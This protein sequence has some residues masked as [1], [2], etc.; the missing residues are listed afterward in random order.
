MANKMLFTGGRIITMAE[1][2]QA[3]LVENGKIQAVGT[4]EELRRQ[5]PDASVR[6]LEGKVL[7]PAFLDG[8]S[9]MTSLATTFQAVSLEKAGSLEE[10]ENL[11]C[12]AAAKQPEGE[13]LIGFGYDHNLLREG[14]H[15]DRMMLDR[16]SDRIP[17]LISHKSGHMGAANTAALRLMGVDL[18]QQDPEG[19]R[20]GRLPDGSLSGYLEETAFTNLA[21]RLPK[22]GLDK[23]LWALE[24]AQQVY[25]SNGITTVQDG[26]TSPEEW[27]LLQEFA[28]QGRLLVDLVCYPPFEQGLELVEAHPEWRTYQNHLRIGGLK[29]FLDGS[30]QGKTAW[31]SRPYEGE[32]EYCGYPVLSDAQAIKAMEGCCKAGLQLLCHCNGDAAAEQ[33][34]RCWESCRSQWEGK[35][36]RP[37][38]IHAQTVRADQLERMAG[39]GMMASFFVAH[40]RYWG[41]IHR[42]N[43]GEERAARISPAATARKLGVPFTFHQD[44][45]VLP[46][47]MLDTLH[48]AVF[49]TTQSGYVL[50][51]EERLAPMEALEAVTRTAAWQYHE[52]G[53]KGVLAP[54]AAADL[55][56]L[57]GDPAGQEKVQVVETIKD[58]KTLWKA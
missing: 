25:L 9:H 51:P 18:H 35:D 37:V 7:M 14:C 49:R 21:T 13:W 38:M 54:G 33:M 23:R 50:G 3:V 39:L 24:Q 20:Y 36:L 45:P 32:T 58:G 11:L 1:D 16:V 52:E 34:I 55:I 22:P 53:K 26:M 29:I 30:P 17:I 12:Q 40:T 46:P 42:K 44:S 8:H 48:C 27:A 41:D 43:L 57:S 5:A 4:E 6:E 2:A 56:V 15:P 31:L 19:G 28:S 10:I 47:D